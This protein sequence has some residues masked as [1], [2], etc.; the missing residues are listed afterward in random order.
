MKDL[1]VSLKAISKS[2]GGIKALDD[3]YFDV[4]NE[5]HTLVGHS[6]AGGLG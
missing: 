5:I 1:K 2:Y 3:V 6:G 4:S